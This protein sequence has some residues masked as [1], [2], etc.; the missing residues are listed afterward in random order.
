MAATRAIGLDHVALSA[1]QER[2]L[3]VGHQQQRLEMTQEFVG[4]PVFGEFD[5]AASEI[6]VIL[7]ELGLEA[8]EQGEGVG[9]RAGKSGENLVVDRGGEFSWPSA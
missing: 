3:F 6:A 9:G 1:E 8:A 7:L 2:L 5:G 4:A